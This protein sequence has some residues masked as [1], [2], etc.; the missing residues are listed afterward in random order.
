MHIFMEV[1]FFKPQTL[2][3]QTIE[4]MKGLLF[5]L[6][7]LDHT[8]WNVCMRH[9]II[10]RSSFYSFQLFEMMIPI[11]HLLHRCLYLPACCVPINFHPYLH[12]HQTLSEHVAVQA[13]RSWYQMSDILP[14]LMTEPESGLG[15]FMAVSSTGK[16]KVYVFYLLVIIVNSGVCDKEVS[17]KK[18]ASCCVLSD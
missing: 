6:V 10:I 14:S 8:S 9:D 12:F 2:Q 4:E 15:P 11:L 16:H 17:S 3:K 18:F 7:E 1:P 13:T 5:L